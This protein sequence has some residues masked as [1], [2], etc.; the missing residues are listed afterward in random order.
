MRTL[1]LHFSGKCLKLYI[2]TFLTTSQFT[3][4]GVDI[5]YLDLLINIIPLYSSYYL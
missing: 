4:Q 2:E 3:K 1:L 5:A